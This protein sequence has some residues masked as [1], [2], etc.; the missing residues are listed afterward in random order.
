MEENDNLRQNFKNN[1][2]RI[3]D[4]KETT[5]R[6][7]AEYMGVSA[8]TVNDWLKG[9]KL[10]R[11]DKFDKLCTYFNIKRTDLLSIKLSNQPTIPSA[12]NI[13]P[14]EL[15]KLPIIGKIAAGKPILAQESIEGYANMADGI[16]ADF[17]LQVQ[18]DSMINARIYNGDIVFIKQQPEVEDGEI[19]AVLIDDSA[20]LKR[21]YHNNSTV[22]LMPENP[23]YKPIICTKDNCTEFKILGK[24]V[25]FQSMV[26]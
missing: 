23:K 19:A 26:R 5:Q 1:L 7:L 3:F 16:H 20:T 8:A 11:M 2:N 12:S 4:S 25:A 9:K 18:G 24:A 21:F 14:I 22:T 6:E 13:R 17:C 15:T 10:P